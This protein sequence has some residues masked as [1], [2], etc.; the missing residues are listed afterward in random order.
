MARHRIRWLVGVAFLICAI[1]VILQGSFS[2]GDFAPHTPQETYLLWAVSTLIFLL[3]VTLGFMLFR[4]GVRLW[5]ER[6]RNRE[7]AGIKVKLVVGALALSFLPV[8]FLVLF[9]V[10]V[11]N[12]NLDK[13]FARPATNVRLHLV[14]ISESWNRTLREKAEAVARLVASAPEVQNYFRGGSFPTQW[15]G[16][17][18]QYGV[19]RIWLV[20]KGE[21]PVLLCR[22]GQ[23]GEASPSREV[24]VSV[25]L[26]LASA[27]PF[28][29]VRLSARMPV[30][31]AERQQQIERFVRDYD[32]LAANRKAIRRAYILL[33][34]LIALFILFVATWI[35]MF[36]AR[37][38]STPISALLEAASEIRKGNLGYRVQV[39]AIDEL[40]SLVRSF[41]AMTEE[42]EAN[43]RELER[44]RR[45]IETIL[46]NI[47]IGVLSIDADGSIRMAN[48]AVGHIF[49]ESALHQ[50]RRWEE[51]FP[52]EESR[53]LRYLVN[54]ARRIGVASRQLELQRDGRTLYLALTVSALGDGT[55]PGFVVLIED[56]T[57]LLQA[58]KLA[59]WREVARRI[60]HELKN[61]LT[62][63]TLC[64]Q[65]I[66]RQVQRLAQEQ[67]VASED[68]QRIL[69]E[70][71]ATITQE[72]ESVRTLVN[73]FAQ[74]ARF[75]AAQPSLVQLNDIVEEAVKVFSGRL[76]DVVVQLDLAPDLPLVYVDRDQFRRVLVNLIDN[77]AEAMEQSP[78]KELQVLTRA[79]GA[80]LV[81]LVV[82]DTGPGV[83]PEDRDKLFLPY[84]SRKEGGTGLGLAIVGQILA[85]HH[86]YIRVEDN[87]P[88]GARFVIEIPTAASLQARW[89]AARSLA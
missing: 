41:N 79:L 69:S 60:A 43:A 48:R 72:V 22:A 64:A 25:S 70:C 63:I 52:P 26:G 55:S 13:W 83:P 67:I 76:G 14:E 19:D 17:C 18:E 8:I 39:K 3:M 74:F 80:D 6:Q 66:V 31:L 21:E 45:F 37:Q 40:A 35:A 11:L 1:L 56:T 4:T 51:L 85:E 89:Q 77:S 54:R 32:R 50:V 20:R 9:S 10:S 46:E 62:P 38:I 16:A 33:L 28:G 86:A 30:D 57:E 12:R 68:V 5:V 65:R 27:E 71:A 24:V 61:P 36:L 7:G 23:P 82:A 2:L 88:H 58:Q 87:I 49:S 29:E 34:S 75:P 53:E 73:E 47:P 44:R 15:A 59:A 42:L 84:F 78:R 81:E